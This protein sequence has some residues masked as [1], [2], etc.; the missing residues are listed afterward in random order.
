MLYSKKSQI[1]RLN[2]IMN[3]VFVF[4][5]YFVADKIYMSAI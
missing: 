3:T 5:W 1:S 2:N 4:A